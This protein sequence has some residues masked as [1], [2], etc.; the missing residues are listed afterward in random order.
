MERHL[1]Y[2]DIAKG[3]GII[4][5]I[6]GHTI[7]PVHEAISIFHMPLFFFLA[8]ITLKVYPDFEQFLL[9]K[10]DR[11]FIPYVFFS[12]LSWIVARIVGYEGSIFNGPLWFLQSLFGALIISEIIL[13]KFNKWG[14]TFLFAFVIYTAI[15]LYLKYPIFPFDTD[16]DLMIRSSVYVLAGYYLKDF[17]FTSSIKDTKL[18]SALVFAVMSV[19]FSVLSY[20]S[21]FKLGAK[22]GFLYGDILR[23]NIVI[24]YLT[25]M[26]GILAVIYLCKIIKVN[27]LL[28]PFIWLGKNSLVIMCVHYPFLQWWNPFISS[29]DYYTNGDIIHKALV[30]ILSYLVAIAF[31]IPFVI[32][33]QRLFPQVSGYKLI[34]SK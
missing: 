10:I 8:G 13:K 32:A 29:C 20:V 11:I 23:Y 14:W 16:F 21:I 22:G 34:F 5:V 18:N 31:S 1:D 25:S 7:F 6:M 33:S 26:S 9:R 4:L 19:L 28:W 27:R 12:L 30:A 24:F 15:S 3:I 2:L 17:V